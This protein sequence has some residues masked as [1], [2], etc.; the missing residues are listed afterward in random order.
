M[1]GTGSGWIGDW[2]PGIGDPSIVGWVTVVAYFV[3]AWLCWQARRGAIDSASHAS[4]RSAAL[5]TTFTLGLL[6]LGINKQLD[7]QTALTEVGRSLAHAHHWYAERRKLQIAFIGAIGLG[8]TLFFL[9]L[10]VAAR[11]ELRRMLIALV[12]IAE[13]GCFVLIRAA[14]FHHVD[15]FIGTSVFGVR[16]NWLLELGGIALVAVGARAYVRS[17][18]FLAGRVTG[19]ERA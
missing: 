3:A 11:R 6:F 14:S 2:S 10:L 8:G 9:F 19:R 5:W 17:G 18:R 13:L 16:M 15:R 12:G 1:T 7:L 4:R